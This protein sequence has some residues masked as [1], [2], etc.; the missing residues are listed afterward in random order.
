MIHT[1]FRE[2]ILREFLTLFRQGGFPAIKPYVDKV[3]ELF[4]ANHTFL[5]QF[6][7]DYYIIP[8]PY[9]LLLIPGTVLVLT[10]RGSKLFF[11]L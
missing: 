3:I 1:L 4:F 2:G 7:P 8:L 11:C 6:L 5:R 10:K 9:Y